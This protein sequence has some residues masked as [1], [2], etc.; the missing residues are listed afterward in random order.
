MVQARIII[1]LAL[2]LLTLAGCSTVTITHHPAGDPPPFCNPDLRNTIA[3]YW[4]T[5][6]R[7]DQKEIKTREKYL[8]EGIS[9]FFATDKC[10]ETV[11]IARTINGKDAM[12]ASDAELVSAGKKAGADKV[13]FL[14]IE[15]LGP[16]LYLYLSP[17]LWQTKNEAALQVRKLNTATGEVESDLSTQWLRGGPFTMLGAGSLPVDLSGVLQAIFYGTSQ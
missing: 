13:F 10:F 5:A 16:N 1:P 2:F 6:W 12:L 4:G 3:V 11:V 17:I 7:N 15:E 8:D 14:R 9:S